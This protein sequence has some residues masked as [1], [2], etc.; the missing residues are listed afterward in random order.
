MKTFFHL[1]QEV[2]DRGLCHRCGGCVSFCT[3]IN[4]GALH[5]DEDGSPCYADV[6]KCIE[7]G[8]CY[9]ICPEIH[10][11]DDEQKRVA[12]WSAPIGRVIEVATAR[13]ADPDIRARATDG[14]VV[15]ALLVHLYNM[16]FID[17]AIVTKQTGPFQRSPWLA[18]T[19]KEIIEAA[20]FHFDASHGMKLFGEEYSTYAPSIQELQEL[21]KQGLRRVAFVGTPC[22]IKAVRK[23]EALGIVPADI[24]RYHFGLFCTGNF[25]FG[26]AE[27]ERLEAAGGF[28]WED[29]ARVNVK[30][31]LVIHLKDGQQRPL[32]LDQ[33]DFMKRY[34][35]RFCD[36]Y[37]AEFA[38]LSFGGLGSEEGW[39]TVLARSVHGRA[40]LAHGRGR[41]VE[42]FDRSA[43]PHLGTRILRT[44]E[45]WSIRKKVHSTDNRDRMNGH[46]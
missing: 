33:L 3:A 1:K 38:D 39:T 37:S 46:P 29:V 14:G 16:G 8:I 13:A 22:Q 43:D 19:Q 24:I 34:A 25:K 44:V 40:I 12:G 28:R 17:G 21:S 7:C 35:C 6:G 26:P 36:D 23:M 9:L 11:L 4:Y 27:R 32:P 30:E 15:T 42:E 41:A 31:S 2:Q 20:G 18:T 45:D 5:I 10:D